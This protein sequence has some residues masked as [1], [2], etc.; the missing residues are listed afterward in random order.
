[1][2]KKRAD[3]SFEEFRDYYENN[4]APLCEKLI[5][6]YTEYKRNFIEPVQDYTTGHLDNNLTQPPNFDV[7]TEVKF[8]SR[9]MYQ[10]MVDA[11]S[12]PAIGD[13]ITR[14]EENLFDRSAMTVY[15]VEEHQS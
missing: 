5:P 15:I 14:D 13:I 12:D 4:H 8:A 1:M 10:K 3:L 2:L 7:V 9:E 6:F 11:L